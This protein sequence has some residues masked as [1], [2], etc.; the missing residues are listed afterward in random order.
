M[1]HELMND[2]ANIVGEKNLNYFLNTPNVYIDG[3]K[4]KKLLASDPQRVLSLAD[5]FAHPADI[6]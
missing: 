5:R 1:V 3:R 6:F 4:P 2:V